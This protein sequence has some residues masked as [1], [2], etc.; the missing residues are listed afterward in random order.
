MI[1]DSAC[2]VHLYCQTE[3]MRHL[4]VGFLDIPMEVY[5]D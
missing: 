4:G 3:V 2:M 5:L 1:S